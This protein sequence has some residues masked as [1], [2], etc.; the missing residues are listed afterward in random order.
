MVDNWGGGVA[1]IQYI[2]IHIYTYI[3][4]TYIHICNSRTQDFD[5]GSYAI[6]RAVDFCRGRP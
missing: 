3:Y 1:Y 5:H 2:Y 4:I 6:G